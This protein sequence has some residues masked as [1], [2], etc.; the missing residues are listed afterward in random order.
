M[1]NVY[2]SLIMILLGQNNH[3]IYIHWILYY[4]SLVLRKVSEKAETLTKSVL[5]SSI[6]GLAL[7][8]NCG[9]YTVNFCIIQCECQKS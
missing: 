8:Q 1:L 9:Y 6:S 4:S 2:R 7:K 5:M 3:S